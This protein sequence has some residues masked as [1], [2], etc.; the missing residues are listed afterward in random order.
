MFKRLIHLIKIVAHALTPKPEPVDKKTAE[1]LYEAQRKVVEH[2]ANGEHHMALADMYRRRI[3]RLSGDHDVG[4]VENLP[5]DFKTG[6][7]LRA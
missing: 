5:V 6:N 7:R 2:E 1:L 4:V 3:A